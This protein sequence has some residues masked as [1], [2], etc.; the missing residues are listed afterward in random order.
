MIK[1]AASSYRQSG[2]PATDSSEDRLGVLL[3]ALGGPDSLESVGPYLQ[4]LRGGRPTPPALIDEITERYRVT[5]G[6][7]PVLAITRELAGKLQRRLRESGTQAN[8]YVG[9]RHWHPSIGE[10]YR[11]I[12]QDGVRRVVGVC[13]APQNSQMTVGAYIRKVEEARAQS[14]APSAF[15]CVRSWNTHPLLIAAIAANIEKT[16]RKFP[17]DSTVPILFTA[18]SLPLRILENQDP[19]RQEVLATVEAVAAKVRP[20]VW[21]FAYQSQGR[22]EEPWLGPTVETMLG[23]LEQAGH[24]QV[25]LAPI[26][27][28]SD[29]VEILYDIDI[30]FKKLAAQK[31]IRLERTPMLNATAPVVE[32]LTSVVQSHLQEIGLLAPA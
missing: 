18:H 8:V 20:E 10:V 9:L 6:K 4:D 25:L 24:R 3:V 1:G 12:E 17:A 15:T 5:G 14:S 27:F 22:S 32:T 29:H 26:G 21:L 13:M 23:E 19:Y 2:M 16:R 7:S 31:G 28:I 30:E 11:Q